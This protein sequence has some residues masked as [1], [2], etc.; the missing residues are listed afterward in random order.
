MTMQFGETEE[1][2]YA[3]MAAGVT[4]AKKERCKNLLLKINPKWNDRLIWLADQRP[5]STTLVL[6]PKSRLEYGTTIQKKDILHKFWTIRPH[7]L[8][9]QGN[10]RV[11]VKG[12][13]R[14]LAFLFLILF[15]KY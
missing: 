2:F 14:F 4:A 5:Y 13:L 11:H 10:K 7:D 12:W 3:V 15:R 8:F 1:E 6:L 9:M